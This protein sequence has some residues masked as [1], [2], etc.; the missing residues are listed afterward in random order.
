MF[1]SIV[2]KQR[3]PSQVKYSS[4]LLIF[5]MNNE[6]LP[7]SD[8]NIQHHLFSLQSLKMV[9][10]L[11]SWDVYSCESSRK[12]KEKILDLFE[13]L[14]NWYPQAKASNVYTVEPTYL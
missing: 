12:T 2:M 14:F 10:V 5:T 7:F 1:L 9:Y 8:F 4:T 13:Y 3:S 6:L 11:A